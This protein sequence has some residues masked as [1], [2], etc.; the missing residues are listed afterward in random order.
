MLIPLL[1]IALLASV[2]QAWPQLLVRQVDDVFLAYRHSFAIA[3]N[4]ADPFDPAGWQPADMLSEFEH[5]LTLDRPEALNH[6]LTDRPD[7]G[8][9]P[10]VESIRGGEYRSLQEGRDGRAYYNH[11]V[12]QVEGGM[13]RFN[14]ILQA[15]DFHIVDS[16]IPL[17]TTSR[18]IDE[19]GAVVTHRTPEHTRM[20]A[21][22]PATADRPAI[23]HYEF[24]LKP[25][26]Y[27]T[28][29]LSTITFPDDGKLE[30][31][32]REMRVLAWLE[33][34][35][36]ELPLDVV[37]V[38]WN[39]NVVVEYGSVNRVEIDAWEFDIAS[40]GT[41]FEIEERNAI[42]DRW[43]PDGGTDRMVYDEHGVCVQREEWGRYSGRKPAR[44]SLLGSGAALAAAGLLAALPLFLV[45]RRSRGKR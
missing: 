26:G 34:E 12:G 10:L 15:L 2:G 44:A 37:F 43:M 1:L 9:V 14:P 21:T 30:P 17:L 35:D 23:Y 22:L 41:A 24:D 40:G 19:F 36:G 27:V 39:P 3:P 18:L 42:V 20:E 5:E 28:R 13:L 16:P 25:S 38:T 33:T 11:V 8:Y 6:F 45:T 29:M 4:G 31:I 7:L 32:T